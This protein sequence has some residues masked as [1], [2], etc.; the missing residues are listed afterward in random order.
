MSENEKVAFTGQEQGQESLQEVSQETT[1]VESEQSTEPEYLTRK[2]AQR[3]FEDQ[4]NELLKQTQSLTD[5]ASSRL[6]KKLRDEIQK[7]N[8][9]MDLQKKAGISITPEQEQNMRRMAYDNALGS[10]TEDTDDLQK[11]VA[12]PKEVSDPEQVAKVA[13]V[14]MDGLVNDIYREIGVTVLDGD[15]EVDL[16]DQSTPSAFLKSIRA[17][18]EKKKQR[19]ETAPEARITSLGKGQPTNLAASLKGQYEERKS[20]IQGDVNALIALKQEFRK[21]GLQI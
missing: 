10:M 20:K 11:G 13:A 12:K 21:K 16:V 2:E 5:K 4:K 1:A 19:T 7:V 9:V 3:L 15:P 18:A 8:D 17:A 14:V 6:D